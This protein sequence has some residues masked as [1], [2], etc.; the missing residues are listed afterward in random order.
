VGPDVKTRAVVCFLNEC[1]DEL[2]IV[3]HRFYTPGE[4]KLV[5]RDAL[6]KL[7]IATKV[8]LLPTGTRAARGLG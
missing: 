4:K 6:G 5:C 3:S 7:F 2:M 1:M 8:C